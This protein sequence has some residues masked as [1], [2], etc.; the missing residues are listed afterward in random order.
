MLEAHARTRAYVSDGL[1][2]RGVPPLC[3]RT[4]SMSS[5]RMEPRRKRLSRQSR[6][7]ESHFSVV[8]GGR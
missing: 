7:T 6:E 5:M 1:E 2:Y 8:V 4:S 3:L